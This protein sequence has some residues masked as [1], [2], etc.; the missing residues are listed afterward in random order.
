MGVV[1]IANQTEPIKRKVALK[2]IRTGMD[3]GSVLARF[4]QERQALAL[5]DHPNIARV[6]D[7]GVIP[8]GSPSLS[9]NWLTGCP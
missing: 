2:V 3:S 1:W 7:G 5:M 4:E 9:W 6:L 8:P